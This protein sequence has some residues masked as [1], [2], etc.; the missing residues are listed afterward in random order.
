MGRMLLRPCG[1]VIS[2][3]VVEITGA[4]AGSPEHHDGMGSCVVGGSC[5]MTGGGRRR[6]LLLS[7]GGSVPS[8]GVTEIVGAAQAPEHDDLLGR[9]VIGSCGGLPRRRLRL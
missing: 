9:F 6:G 4:G 5:E 1:A 8:P 2:P 3:G 7:P